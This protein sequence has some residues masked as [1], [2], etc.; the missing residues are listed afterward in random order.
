MVNHKERII[1]YSQLSTT[2]VDK[3]MRKTSIQT[4]LKHFK[5]SLPFVWCFAWI[6]LVSTDSKMLMLILSGSLSLARLHALIAAT[7]LIG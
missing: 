7:E 1:G 5:R 6:I 4:I 2:W 3:S